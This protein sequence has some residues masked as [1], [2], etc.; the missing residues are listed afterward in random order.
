MTNRA[1]AVKTIN[2]PC[3]LTLTR[4]NGESVRLDGALAMSL[5]DKSVRIRAWKFN[6]A[7]FDLTLTPAGLWVELPRD[8]DRRP[9]VLPASLSA[10]QLARALSLFGP[11]FFE[12]PKPTLSDS[13]GAR[14]ELAKAVEQNQTMV[15]SVD[16]AT[17]TVRQYRLLG[18]STAV[19]FTLDLLQYQEF[20][21]L[22]WPT[23]L[24]ALNNGSRIDLELRDPQLNAALPPQAFVPP[25]R[26]EKLP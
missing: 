8:P 14:F 15:A 17:L 19:R 22:A 25:R 12:G 2:S 1:S 5:P 24:V 16:R 7:V 13:G 26:A 23:R 9:Q 20:D 21:G 3:A 4:A 10:A 18:P 11:D 6:T